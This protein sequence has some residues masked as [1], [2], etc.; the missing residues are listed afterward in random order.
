[1]P[2]IT[3]MF[4][5]LK[6]KSIVLIFFVVAFSLDVQA[7]NS[8]KFMS[9][10]LLNYPIT[11]D[12]VNDTTTRHPNY[13]TVISSVNP[14]ILL[15]QETNTSAGVGFFLT[16]VMN[17]NGNV[18]SAATYID[19][20]DTDNGCFYKTSKFTFISNTAIKTALR[21][22]NE[23][24][25]VHIPTGDTLRI[26]SLHLKAS[27][28]AANEALR[29]AEVDSLRKFTNS[30]P[31]GSK[32]I[33]CGD[34]NIYGSTEPAYTKLLQ[35]TAGN[36]GHFYDPITMS[37]IWNNPAYAIYHTQSPRVRS[38]GGGATGGL[39]DRFDMILFSKA[40]NDGVGMS[41]QS[42]SMTA[43]GNDG[44]HLNDS[45]NKMPNTAV[46]ATIANAIHNASDHLPVYATFN[47]SSLANDVGAID[48]IPPT[49]GSCN[50]NNKTLTVSIKNFA[51]S[52]LNFSTSP[53][54]VGIKITNPSNVVQ[55]L[56]T[57]VTS[58][59]IAANGTLSVV[60]S[61]TYNFTQTGN[62]LFKAFTQATGDIS[63][64]NDS[65][66]VETVV[67][68]TGFTASI[69]P[70]G[71]I[72]IC[73][74]SST[75]LTATS[76]TNFL[77]SN[78]STTSSINVSTAGTYTVTVTNGSG[79]TSIS[80]PVIVSVSTSN[81]TAIL[82]SESMGT[83][84]GTTTIAAHETANG[85]DNDA[86]TM[87]GTGDVRVT[88]TSSGYPTATAGANVFLTGTVGT[89]NFIIS[90][91]NTT[92][93]SNLQL[94][95]GIWKNAT[96]ATGADFEVLVSSDGTNY[97]N[98]NFTAII[99]GG[100]AWY[101]KTATGTIPST[102]NL[103]I[104]FRNNSTTNQYRI[105]DV[106]LNYTAVPT[107]NAFGATTFCN[108]DSVTLTA[109]V[110]SNYLWSTGATTQ[111]I[112]VK[113]SGNYVV[114]VNCVPSA[115]QLVTVNN[116]NIN[117]QVKL[118][119]QGLSVGVGIMQNVL[120]SNGISSDPLD[121]DSVIVELRQAV[122]PY[123]IV[124]SKTALLKTNGIALL[125]ISSSFIGQSYYIVVKH[126]NSIESWSKNPVLF[127]GSLVNMDFT[128]P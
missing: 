34:F 123:S 5:F 52:S 96:A 4:S 69:S 16:R 19:G 15:T 29:A 119:L 10:N 102:T 45:I 80:G 63:I 72:T 77:W 108:G 47:F 116:C 128:T 44:N 51:T 105:D 122:A 65:A 93:L 92:G 110:G 118:F 30:L 18:Y 71:P 68:P 58:G 53:V 40:I 84:A 25:L 48:F 98:L 36:T 124:S 49:V 31:G 6:F 125:S 89:R 86:F 90:N 59:T 83:V 55:T 9:Y 126:R 23:F 46:S 41:Y 104:Q 64:N 20:P 120:Y 87:S 67:V 61:S 21:D 81:P 115:A 79:C 1:M 82:F 14:D 37:G 114:T 8:I 111:S 109:S 101:Y 11:S 38:F 22:I 50:N 91:I 13:R 60:V 33:V 85:F 27:S 26:F 7:Q 32:F 2:M 97:S 17:A 39:D 74:G 113:V 12:L 121:C 54:T 100:S 88:S 99:G 42:N 112:S 73:N 95:F 106:Q 57:N 70:T 43:Y 127:T 76:G 3:Q 28:G 62:Y 35:V 24:K 117:L 103:R 94:S 107:I 78:G 66:I 75:T 56:T